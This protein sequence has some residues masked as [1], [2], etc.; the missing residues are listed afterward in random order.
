MHGER[1]CG[2][3]RTTAE[4]DCRGT[5]RDVR[6][7]LRERWALDKQKSEGLVSAAVDFRQHSVFALDWLRMVE[8]S[9]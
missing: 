2:G 9:T 4:T 5:S 6:R 8:L 7:S 3:K 1:G